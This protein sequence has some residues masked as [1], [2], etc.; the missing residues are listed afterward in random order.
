MTQLCIGICKGRS[1]TN[2]RYCSVIALGIALTMISPLAVVA[3]RS[4]QMEIRLGFGTFLSRDRGWNYAEPIE[5]FVGVA[6]K[7]GAMDVEAAASVSKSF[8]SFAYPAIPGQE[9]GYYDGFR[10]RLGL[11]APNAAR[12]LVSAIVGAEFVHNNGERAVRRS[13]IAGTVG[14]G[15]NLGPERRG[16]ID[17]RYVAF[18][19]RL[20]TSRGVLPLTFA[21]RL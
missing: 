18:A 1:R 7:A 2:A 19:N 3:Q 10:L 6:R 13:T 9:G 15:L 21:W 11:R 14:L 8:V 16:T 20:G 4:G 17:L 12:S 5:V